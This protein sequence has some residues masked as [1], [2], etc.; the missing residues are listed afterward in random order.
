MTDSILLISGGIDS[1]ALAYDL[2][3]DLAITVDYGQTPAEAEI[4]ASQEI[5][6]ELGITHEVLRFDTSE[7]GTGTMSAQD[8]IEVASTPEWWPFRNQLIITIAAI[9]A[10]KRGA[11]KLIIGTVESDREHADGTPEFLRLIDEL[12]S[13][14]EG[15]LHISAPAKDLTSKE[16]VSE[17][18]ISPDLLGWTHSCHVSNNP[19]GTCR[20]CR[21]RQDVVDEIFRTPN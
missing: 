12:V 15:E 2:G 9:D 10:V 13:L 20:G 1:A 4:Q 3:P 18:G 21:K 16:L 5:C 7:L 6:R 14:Q 17:T 8:Q 11:E 19:C